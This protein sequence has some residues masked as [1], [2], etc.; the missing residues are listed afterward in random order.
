MR[1]R[2]NAFLTVWNSPQRHTRQLRLRL[3]RQRRL[4]PKSCGELV[5]ALAVLFLP[6]TDRE[7][8]W[9]PL[10]RRS[11]NLPAGSGM[12]S[13]QRIRKPM[14]SGRSFA[15]ES[16]SAVTVTKSA[17]RLFDETWIGYRSCAALRV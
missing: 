11:N 1:T 2:A 17:M 3:R 8:R 7:R 15:D 6:V 10:L 4:Q 12:L 16:V 5:R 13:I 14:S 9:W